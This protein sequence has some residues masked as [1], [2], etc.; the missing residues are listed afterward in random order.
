VIISRGKT[1]GSQT[2]DCQIKQSKKL[3][4][5]KNSAQ[6][7]SLYVYKKNLLAVTAWFYIQREDNIRHSKC[8]KAYAT[9]KGNTNQMWNLI[10]I[11]NY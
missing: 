9:G 10:A 6:F 3:L 8:S 4:G 7:I 5:Y 11:C 2:D 1:A